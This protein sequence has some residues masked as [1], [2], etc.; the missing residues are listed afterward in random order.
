MVQVERSK[1]VNPTAIHDN[2][3]LIEAALSLDAG[4]SVVVNSLETPKDMPMKNRP[5]RDDYRHWLDAQRDAVVGGTSRRSAGERPTG[6]AC[7]PCPVLPP[8]LPFAG[9]VVWFHVS[10]TYLDIRFDHQRFEI[11]TQ[12]V[13][14]PAEAFYFDQLDAAYGHAVDVGE[15]CLILFSNAAGA[16]VTV[17]G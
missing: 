16:P 6:P 8:A 9:Y 10:L 4:R 3:A 12:Q 11:V 2:H 7:P 14:S 5:V 13:Q 17:A 1:F 15:P